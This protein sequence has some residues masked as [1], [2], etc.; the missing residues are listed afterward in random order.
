MKKMSRTDFGVLF[1]EPI[2]N[3]KI[4]SAF[5]METLASILVRSKLARILDRLDASLGPLDMNLPGYRLHQLSGK[6]KGTWS[7]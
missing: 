2:F 5:S 1:R 7:V 6:G 3:D 4:Y